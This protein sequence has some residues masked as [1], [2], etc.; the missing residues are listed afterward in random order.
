MNSLQLYLNIRI[1]TD[2]YIRTS[3]LDYLHLVRPAIYTFYME[4]KFK[5]TFKY[6][7][8]NRMGLVFHSTSGVL[9]SSPLLTIFQYHCGIDLDRWQT[10][11]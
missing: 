3:I 7:D 10:D 11:R 5:H 1:L 4:S 2:F 9:W 8:G 6:T